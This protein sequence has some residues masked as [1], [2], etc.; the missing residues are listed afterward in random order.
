MT[1]INAAGTAATAEAPR[2]AARDISPSRRLLT[3]VFLLQVSLAERQQADLHG[4]DADLSAATAVIK[5]Q[6]RTKHGSDVELGGASSC[7]TRSSGRNGDVWA[8]RV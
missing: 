2:R 7:V 5:K 8:A 1:L 4:L 3:F 6:A